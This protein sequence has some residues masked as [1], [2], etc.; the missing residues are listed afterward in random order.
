MAEENKIER[1][2]GREA[3][4]V[5]SVRLRSD[6]AALLEQLS[7]RDG[8]TMSETLRIALRALERE[9]AIG[10][11][12]LRNAYGTMGGAGA[13]LMNEDLLAKTG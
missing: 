6:E 5:V 10:S 8:R 13:V 1:H 2:K 3:G 4:I 12:P 9:Q 11:I 7:E